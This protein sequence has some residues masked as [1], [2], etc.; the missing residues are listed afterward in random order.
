MVSLQN[1]CQ[2]TTK[3]GLCKVVPMPMIAPTL[4]NPALVVDWQRFCSDTILAYARMQIGLLHEITPG[5]PVTHNLRALSRDFDHFDMAEALDFVAVDSNATIK[6]RSA[7]LAC[8]I[9]MMRSLK[10]ENIRTPN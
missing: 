2:S 1:R 7:E 5:I 4:H 6:S 9:D 10:K 3:A 8:E